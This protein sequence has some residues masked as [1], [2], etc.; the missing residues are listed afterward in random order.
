LNHSLHITKAKSKGKRKCDALAQLL[1]NE[2]GLEVVTEYRFAAEMVGA[3]KGIRERL[4]QH[5]LQDWRFDVAITS[6]LIAI[7]LDG[8]T[9]TNGAHNRG[10]HMVSDMNKIN[11]ATVNGW[12]VLRFTH[13]HH[14]HSEIVDLVRRLI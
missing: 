1:R 10:S 8:G 13:T 12:R 3:G 2:L 11:T 6:N 7:E 4:K 9:W 14:K 5:G